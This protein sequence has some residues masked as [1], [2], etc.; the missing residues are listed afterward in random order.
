MI[1]RKLGHFEITGSIG[2]GGMGVV[3]KATDLR[4]RRTV[5]IKLLPPETAGDSQGR[6]RL[7]REARAASALNHPN[8]VTVY[9]IDRAEG[10]GDFI[11]MEFVEGETLGAAVARG[12]SIEEALGYARQIAEALAA[13]HAAGIVHRDLKPGNVIVKPGGQV[14]VLDFGLARRIAVGTLDT[15]A[16]TASVDPATAHGSVAGTLAYMSPEQAEGRPLDARS[17]IFSFGVVLYEMLT[18]RRP[19]AGDSGAQVLS[20]I[21]RDTPPAARS[22][23]KELPEE[24]DRILS[25]ALEKDV[26]YRYQHIAD[27][28]A[29]L[30]RAGRVPATAPLPGPAGSSRRLAWVLGIAATLALAFVGLRLTTPRRAATLQFRLL[31]TFPGSHRAPSLSPD[32]RMLA[33][34][35]DASGVPQIWVKP[36]GEGD[37]VQITSGEPAAGNPRWSP[38]GDQIVFERSRKGLWSVPPLGGAPRQILEQ[39]NCPSFFPDGERL[40]LD[41]GPQLWVA[42]VDGS[43]LRRVE[44]VQDNFYSFFLNHCATVSPDGRWLA[45]FQPQWGPHGDYWMIS[46]AGGTPRRLTS[47]ASAGGGIVFS[48][49]GRSVIV[50]SARAGSQTLW[51]VPLAGGPAE[52]ITTGAGEDMEPALS[53]DGRTLVYSNAR[54]S[55]AIM[56]LDTRTGGSR[57]LLERRS[58]TNGAVF[59]PDGSRIAF[60][61]GTEQNEQIFT[62]G[63][64]GRDLRQV[65]HGLP[66]VYIMPRFTPDGASLYFF[67]HDPPSFRRIPASGGRA[68]TVVDGWLWGSVFGAW[69]DPAGRCVAYTTQERRSAMP[70]RIRDLATGQ[71]RPLAEPIGVNSW[72]RDGRAVLGTR[73]DRIVRCPADGSPCQT[74]GEGSSPIPSG[75]GSRIFFFRTGRALDDRTLRSIDVWVMGA[76]GKEPRKVARLEPQ[77]SLATPFDVSPSDEIV[78]VQF[79]RGKEELWL[80]QLPEEL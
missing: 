39:G 7:E 35:D 69:P 79:R 67:T 62:V 22:L 58:H 47:D 64:D 71:E 51:R 10:L 18:G 24:L 3:Y 15:A 46:A 9:E 53:A 48:R 70:T 27:V 33:F 68:E 34:V 73:E 72:S 37:P 25:K 1:G 26:A 16:P 30:R 54:N 78:W 76:D 14:K 77:S 11:A 52:P 29:D 41:R 45:Y 63:S 66:G 13:A 40:V 4:L 38:K 43:E 75:D 80:A 8:I 21:L 23:R 61:S 19:F 49:D 56:L 42:R 32:G 31:S 60:F 50:S 28:L 12:L 20:A 44:G 2:A 36:V 57:E 74:L 65:T 59:S 6:S 55:H 17:D 5:A